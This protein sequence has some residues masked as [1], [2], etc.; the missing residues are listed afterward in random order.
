MPLPTAEFAD[1]LASPVKA[2]WHS[3]GLD[4]CLCVDEA[5]VSRLCDL[6][7]QDH[8]RLVEKKR[9]EL[10]HHPVQKEV[11]CVISA[12]SMCPG[13][14]FRSAQSLCHPV[15]KEVRCLCCSLRTMP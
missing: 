12:F 2:S 11:R 9:Y 3:I 5:H 15:Q 10:E 6:S 8:E 4:F 14:W 7:M 1:D 13:I